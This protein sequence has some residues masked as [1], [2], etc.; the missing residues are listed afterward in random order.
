[1]PSFSAPG[2]ASCASCIPM[3]YLVP[4]A[5][6]SAAPAEQC[7]ICPTGTTCQYTFNASDSE[8]GALIGFTL[9][10]LHLEPH[11][12]RFNSKVTRMT[13]CTM[14]YDLVSPCKGG[15]DAGVDGE[16][17]CEEGHYGP[18]CELC[19]NTSRYFEANDGRCRDCPV[20]DEIGRTLG[21]I[22]AGVAPVVLLLACLRLQ[23][24]RCRAALV[25]IRRVLIKAGSH[26]LIPKIKLLI[27]LYQTVISIPTVYDVALPPAY[28]RWMKFVTVVDINIDALVVP[29]S[30]LPGGFHSRLLLR[31]LAP[32]ALMAFV[33][34]FRLLYVCCRDRGYGCSPRRIGKQLMDTLP[35]VLFILFCFC[36]SVSKGVFA[37]WSCIE[38]DDGQHNS[39][40]RFLRADLSIECDTQVDELYN[41]IST[42]AQWLVGLWPLGT[43]ILFFLMLIPIRRDLLQKRS[44]RFVQDTAF[45]HREYKP[46]F[47]FWES[48]F[49]TQRLIIIGFIENIPRD[50]MRLQI[51]LLLTLVYTLCLLFVQPY[52][53]RDVGILAVGVQV[54]LIGVF[55]GALNIKLFDDLSELQTAIGAAGADQQIA[56]RVTGF[57]SSDQAAIA[58]FAF[59]MLGLALF[60]IMMGYT[61]ATQRDVST[62]RLK[63]AGSVPELS[64]GERQR[65]HIFLSHV[66]SSGQDQVA[67][68]KRQL[69]LLVP[70]VSVFLDVDECAAPLHPC[71]TPVFLAHAAL[72]FAR[73][74][75]LQ[76]GGYLDAR[77]VHRRVA[78]RDGLP[79]E[80]LLLLSQLPPGARPRP[81]TAQAD[82]TR[83]RG[84]PLEGRRAA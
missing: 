76:L 46:A 4:D 13:H 49:L 45:L 42:T 53:R 65:F 60:F 16:G 74:V 11:Y 72:H 14:N 43:P 56:N 7:S 41:E 37:T 38:V 15:D 71:V 22:A 63:G 6:P 44:T 67:T 9:A 77:I 12:W 75:R 48:I 34:V 24:R 79:F 78:V 36:G 58:I 81:R 57:A 8:A 70:G 80:G 17:Y 1:M 28:Y 82:H 84:R 64:L 29:G 73:C 50:F 23:P 69:Q 18:L 51:G 59:N 25:W 47:F 35:F 39:T 54:A 5:G 26:A 2:S 52:K 10:S 66:W 68:I 83:S 30:C 20:P 32:I 21:Y 27:A 3:Y 31:G 55:F 40:R 33:A 62:I 61:L 19:S